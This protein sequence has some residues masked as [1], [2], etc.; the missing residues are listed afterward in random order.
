[1]DLMNEGATRLHQIP[2]SYFIVSL[3]AASRFSSICYIVRMAECSA[4][5]MRI[6]LQLALTLAPLGSLHVY[7]ISE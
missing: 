4:S 3:C 1:M 2:R 7:S 5:K 6:R